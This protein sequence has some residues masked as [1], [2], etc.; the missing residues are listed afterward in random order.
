[1]RTPWNLQLGLVLGGGAARGLAHVGVIRALQREGIRVHLV[2]GTSVGSI[3]G[4]AWA[5]TQ[6]IG[7]LERE[8]RRRLGDQHLLYRALLVAAGA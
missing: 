3:I 5:A 1:M 6:D 4:G 7:G 2:A 8:L